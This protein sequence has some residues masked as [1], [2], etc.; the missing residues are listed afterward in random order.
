MPMMN[1][2]NECFVV[3]LGIPPVPGDRIHTPVDLIIV[4]L[5]TYIMFLHIKENTLEILLR[6]IYERFQVN[7]IVN[8]KG[9][10]AK[11]HSCASSNICWMLHRV[12]ILV[13]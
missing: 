11:R 13:G 10:S 7:L 5:C 6:T 12:T 8:F 4:K 3:G 9:N 2:L 1:V